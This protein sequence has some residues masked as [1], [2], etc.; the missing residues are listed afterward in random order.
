MPSNFYLKTPKRYTAKGSRRP[1]LNLRWLWLY[2]LA[3]FI[4]IPSVLAWNMRD[5]LSKDVGIW[6][7][8]AFP[9][10][11]PSIT[12]LPTL[13]GDPRS[14]LVSS[15][16]AG[17]INKAIDVMRVIASSV[18]NDAGIRVSI[19]EMLTLR[20]HGTDTKLIDEGIAAAQEAINANPESPAGW[21]ALAL[22]LDWSGQP[23]RALG[24]ILQARQI[25][26]KNPM[27][28]AVNAEI[29]NDLKKYEQAAK[30]IDEAI[31]T[32]RSAK[33]IDIVALSHAHYVKATIL[34][35]T[36][37]QQEAIDEYEQAWRV[38]ISVGP[39]ERV[40]VGYIARTLGVITFASLGQ[41][42]KALDILAK[43][44]DKDKD[45]P[46]L[47][48]WLGSVWLNK[49]DPNKARSYL[50]SCRDLNPDQ[51][52]CLRMLSQ[53]LFRDQNYQKALESL[54]HM[55]TLGTE[56]PN[57]YLRAGLSYSNLNQCASAIP[58]LQQGLKY[59]TPDD[60][61]TFAN[62]EDALRTCGTS[63]ALLAGEDLPLPTETVDSAAAPTQEAA[64]TP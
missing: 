51:M 63:A 15:L 28:M 29:L 60:A 3:P 50:E 47:L 7:K 10:P 26:N 22:A 33:P 64:A 32:A 14:E 37:T 16:N 61:Q 44:S 46:V 2:L 20:S 11:I 52:S 62:F 39:E 58:F 59:I 48:Y 25:D 34:E 57:D 35:N 13:A 41:P 49:G 43:A 23:E 21:G 9:T 31:E 24:Y 56:E 18:P 4:I 38:G 19:S 1:L 12:P 54:T 36:A 6:V 17:R 55:F 8:N 53:I 45:D 40:P 5:Q 42:D 30:L 27:L